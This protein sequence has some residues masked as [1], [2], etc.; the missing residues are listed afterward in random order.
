MSLHFNS[1]TDG[2]PAMGLYSTSP[3]PYDDSSLPAIAM[4]GDEGWGWAREAVVRVVWCAMVY[5]VSGGVCGRPS[6]LWWAVMAAVLPYWAL[7]IA[8]VL[9]CWW[10]KKVP[11]GADFL[12]LP[13]NVWYNLGKYKSNPPLVAG[14]VFGEGSVSKE[15]VELVLRARIL[16]HDRFSHVLHSRRSAM[17][18]FQK[19]NEIDMD[20]HL[21]YERFDG[22]NEEHF[23]DSVAEALSSHLDESKPLWQVRFFDNYVWKDG[24]P[25]GWALL[26]K[27]HHCL[28]DGIGFFQVAQ[29]F[30]K[31]PFC[32]P[33]SPIKLDASAEDVTFANKTSKPRPKSI[34]AFLYV[35]FQLLLQ[36]IALPDNTVLRVGPLS[37]RKNVAWRYLGTVDEIKSIGK[38]WGGT[39]NSIVLSCTTRG[40]GDAIEAVRPNS[41]ASVKSVRVGFAGNLR[42]ELKPGEVAWGNQIGVMFVDLPV[43]NEDLSSK[44][45]I[46][47][48]VVEKKK[49]GEALGNLLAHH[50]S[51]L[52]PLQMFKLLM[53][54]YFSKFS[55]CFT[56]I[57]GPTS[58][59]YFAGKKVMHTVGF[60]PSV[61]TAP[62]GVGITSHSGL[63]YASATVDSSR[64]VSPQVILDGICH[65]FSR[66]QQNPSKQH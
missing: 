24:K 31:D 29:I 22:P 5:R 54:A 11:R 34:A 15:D 51:G 30:D 58:Q 1:G 17:P 48:K 16:S 25:V 64:P 38:Q 39:F 45:K 60:V 61:G 10:W 27:A 2:L 66:Y 47:A 36:L 43:S 28:V 49:K 33:G 21:S 26:V 20:Y 50:I 57:S 44:N 42:P 65:E 19:P 6:P 62:I 55:L 13:D 9:C 41:L 18:F 37:G 23:N 12:G 8:L 32:P 53:S 4:M 7:P 46:L 3:S 56:T 59:F 63:V 35:F 14:I 40:I 52:A